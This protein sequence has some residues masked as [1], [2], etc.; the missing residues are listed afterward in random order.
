MAIMI[1][2][3]F[4]K[5]PDFFKSGTTSFQTLRAF[6]VSS[7]GGCGTPSGSPNAGRERAGVNVPWAF[8]A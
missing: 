4:A 6:A 8:F 3:T 5:T 1:R 7:V 2:S